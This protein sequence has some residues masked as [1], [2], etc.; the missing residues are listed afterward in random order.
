MHGPDDPLQ[1]Q[2]F[3]LQD[4]EYRAFHSRLMPTVDPALVIGVRTPV[5]RAFARQFAKTP[6]AEEFLHT[7]PHKY[8]EENNLHG[9]L[10]S[11]QT[12]PGAAIAALDEFLP[13]VNNWATCDLIA[14]AAFR[15]CPPQLLPAIRRWLAGDHPYTVRFGM[16]M[17]LRFYLDESFQPEYLQWVAAVQ[18][19]EYYVKMMQAW[20]FAEALAKQP[21]AA[22]PYLQQNRLPRWGHNKAIQKAIESRRISPAQKAQLRS[23]KRK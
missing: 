3:A 9:M 20:Y 6:Q 15:R 23:L 4:A 22:L 14:P 10:L 12:D 19:E 8:Y 5:L 13:Y 11:A 18:S 21:A 7:L 2:L 17:L 1:Q 16:G